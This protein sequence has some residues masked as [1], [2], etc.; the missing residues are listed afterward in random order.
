MKTRLHP[1]KVLENDSDK[2]QRLVKLY[3]NIILVKEESTTTAF[4]VPTSDQFSPDN[5][6]DRLVHKHV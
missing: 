2:M 3:Y 1:L 5:D 4:L 6:D